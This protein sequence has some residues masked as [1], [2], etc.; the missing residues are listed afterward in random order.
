MRHSFAL[1][2]H[3]KRYAGWL[4]LG[5]LWLGLGS[6]AAV[7]L[8]TADRPSP[9]LSQPS[10]VPEPLM[11][12]AQA[13]VSAFGQPCLEKSAMRPSASA[14]AVIYRSGGCRIVLVIEDGTWEIR[15]L[16]LLDSAGIRPPAF[17]QEPLT[18]EA[19]TRKI[20]AHWLSMLRIVP[21]GSSLSLTAG[22]PR[23]GPGS[24]WP[25]RWQAQSRQ[26]RLWQG[27]LTLDSRTGL[28]LQL[29]SQRA[30]SS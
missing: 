11:Q 4:V 26:G 21:A 19:Q 3:Q 25:L 1:S 23:S 15:N 24:A 10:L 6:A 8:R 20:G 12:Q 9:P 17:S 14:W 22:A 29:T 5:C 7:Y 27:T 28:L 18:T 13:V 30:G 16:V 2:A